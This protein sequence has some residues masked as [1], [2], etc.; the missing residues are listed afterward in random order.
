[1]TKQ[2]NAMDTPTPSRPATLDLGLLFLRVASA[3]MLFMVH[4]M[5]KVLDYANELA[6][7]E[8]PFGLGPNI[9]LWA[10]IFAEVVCPLFIA[11]GWFARLACLPI[12]VVL[13]IAMFVVHAS[14]SLEQGQ[15]GWLL[16]ILFIT[17]AL[18]GPGRW[19]VGAHVE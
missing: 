12:I 13:A 7:I 17:I 6:R 4:G 1:L 14:W 19:R 10:A 3:L 8:D 2:A 18:C 5:P 15:F 11:L 16:M 9:S